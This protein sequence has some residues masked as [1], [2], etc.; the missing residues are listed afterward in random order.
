MPWSLSDN[1]FIFQ[2]TSTL[3]S[4]FRENPKNSINVD[5]V[6]DS[7]IHNKQKGLE[8][9]IFAARVEG[10][11]DIGK[12]HIIYSVNLSKWILEQFLGE[13][14]RTGI[15]REQ[16]SPMSWK[17]TAHSYRNVQ[18]IHANPYDF[19][20]AMPTKNKSNSLK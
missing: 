17:D 10:L 4:I 5:W 13:L 6:E 12:Q 9:V 7:G 19:P 15:R 20:L 18:I 3:L 14:Q 11:R 1:V 16:W 2:I 8:N